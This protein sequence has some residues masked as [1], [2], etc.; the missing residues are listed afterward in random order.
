MKEHYTVYSLCVITLNLICT[1][2]YQLT[3]YIFLIALFNFVY[4]TFTPKPK[5]ER[6]DI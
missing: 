1:V 5:T 6:K 3:I 2:V 4:S